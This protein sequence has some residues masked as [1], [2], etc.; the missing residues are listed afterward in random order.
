MCP[1][2]MSESHSSSYSNKN[3]AAAAVFG[4]EWIR[5][6]HFHPLN[7]REVLARV[8]ELA[9]QTTRPTVLFDLDSTLYEVGPRTFQILKEWCETPA[10]A[11]CAPLQG[12]LRGLRLDQVGYS[13][14]DTLTGLGLSTED[15]E[16]VALLPELKA[17][18]SERFFSSAYLKW[19]RA[20]P[21][22]ARF[23]HELYAMGLTVVYLTGRDEPRMGDGTRDNLVRDGFPW[24]ERTELLLKSHFEKPDLEHKRDA[25]ASV[26][27]HG[28]L[29]ASFEN[30]PVNLVALAELFPDAMHVFVETVYSDHVAPLGRELYRIRGFG[31][32]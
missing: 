1:A 15:H 24:G 5:A 2:V 25:A 22:A 30:E 7:E 31:R 12:A 21:G 26:R 19:D 3:P 14:V 6:S 8:L 29:V 28:N 13:L 27:R 18:W 4:A 17:Y 20:Y 9:R 11:R 16:I 23:A 10:A 32:D